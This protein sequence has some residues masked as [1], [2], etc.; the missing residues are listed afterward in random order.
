MNDL[1]LGTWTLFVDVVKHFLGNHRGENYKELVEKLLKSLQNIS[2][3][4]SIKVHFLQSYLHGFLDNCSQQG[5]RFH[6]DFKT[7]EGRYQG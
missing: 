4:M 1:E 7:M 2:A 6:Q 3:N 5:E